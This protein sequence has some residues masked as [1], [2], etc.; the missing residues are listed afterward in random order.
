MFAAKRS[1]H[2]RHSIETVVIVIGFRLPKTIILNSE[3]INNS[4]FIYFLYIYMI[5]IIS[6][7]LIKRKLTKRVCS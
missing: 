6:N 7:I 4:N 3:K 1:N 5:Y 2:W